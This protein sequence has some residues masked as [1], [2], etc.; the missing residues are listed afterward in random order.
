MKA[1]LIS[2]NSVLKMLNEPAQI[3]R[4]HEWTSFVFEGGLIG[5]HKERLKQAPEE[6]RQY[7]RERC[8]YLF[9]L[10]NGRRG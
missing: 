4:R 2:L 10:G 1:I 7:V 3:A 8:E 5:K 9:N 6:I